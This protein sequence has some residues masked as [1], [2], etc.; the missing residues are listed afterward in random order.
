MCYPGLTLF[1]LQKGRFSGRQTGELYFDA[2]EAAAYETNVGDYWGV[3]RKRRKVICYKLHFY[4]H[5]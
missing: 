5:N 1:L 4:C 2:H 3:V